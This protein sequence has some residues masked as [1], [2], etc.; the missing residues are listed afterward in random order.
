[1]NRRR[2]ARVIAGAGFFLPAALTACGG[3]EAPSAPATAITAATGAV[4]RPTVPGAT[5]A[6]TAIV[7]LPQRPPDRTTG[8]NSDGWVLDGIETGQAGGKAFFALRC[9]APPGEAG[10]PRTD[11]WFEET[12]EQYIL[13]IHGV[14]GANPGYTL[15]PK[16]AQMLTNRP[17]TGYYAPSLRSAADD[18]VY[19]LVLTAMGARGAAWS[20]MG[21]KEPGMVHFSVSQS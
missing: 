21:G 15:R 18:S 10:A 7:G 17:L 13:Q 5:D 16:D 2:F 12:P 8:A 20:L 1:M 11:A 6:T 19:L 14:R 3:N 4:A 9:V